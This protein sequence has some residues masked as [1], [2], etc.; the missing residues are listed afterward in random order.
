V[1][2][3]IG[4]SV[5]PLFVGLMFARPAMISLPFFFAGTLKIVSDLLS[6]RGFVTVRPHEG[7]GLMSALFHPVDFCPA[8]ALSRSHLSEGALRFRNQEGRG[9]GS[10]KNMIEAALGFVGLLANSARHIQI[11]ATH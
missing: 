11:P 8:S 6:Y 7:D 3:T 1:A 10:A 5:A 4:A 9:K 2:R